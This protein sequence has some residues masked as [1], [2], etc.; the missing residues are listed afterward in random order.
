MIY[1]VITV[2]RLFTVNSL[3]HTCIHIQYFYQ[4]H[5]RYDRMTSTVS[6]TRSNV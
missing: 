6:N 5:L 1:K 3:A 4:K 2:Y